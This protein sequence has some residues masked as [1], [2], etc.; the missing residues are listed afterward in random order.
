MGKVADGQSNHI[1]IEYFSGTFDGDGHTIDNLTI[2]SGEENQGL[3]GILS[4]GGAVE[5]CSVEGDISGT[6]NVGGVVGKSFG[7]VKNCSHFGSVSASRTSAGGIVGLLWDNCSI[8]N[9][10]NAGTVSAKDTNNYARGVI[11]ADNPSGVNANGATQLGKLNPPAGYKIIA[12]GGIISSGGEFFVRDGDKVYF[13]LEPVD[14]T[15][16][17]KITSVAVGENTYAADAQGEFSFTVSGNSGVDV[18]IAA[19]YYQLTATANSVTNTENAVRIVGSGT[20]DTITSNA[21]NVSISGGGGDD[22][23]INTGKNTVIEYRAGD[24]SDVI[25]GFNETSTLKIFDANGRV[26]CYTK[27]ES[28]SDVVLTVG[29]ST[30]KDAASIAKLTKAST[31]PATQPAKLSGK[32]FRLISDISMPTVADGESNHTAIGN[33]YTNFAGTFDGAGYT[34]DNLKI[35]SSADNQGLFGTVSYGT[36]KNVRLTNAEISGISN[37]GGVVGVAMYDSKI[38]NCAHSGSVST[39]MKNVGGIVGSLSTSSVENCVNAGAVSSGNSKKGV[40]C[41]NDGGAQVL[42]TIYT[43]AGETV[44]LQENDARNRQR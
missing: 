10:I 36:V 1:A 8:E 9:C 30:L 22:E 19:T 39:S 21:D 25:T 12:I 37:V 38:K 3:F 18:K 24:G 33:T 35:S 29:T 13:K 31:L 4:D 17:K 23:I 14:A 32:T 34:I 40:I 44:T 5:N 2:S 41:Y 11:Y 7:T 42:N 27:S 43:A 15:N 16:V 20:N 26:A 6:Q 28:G